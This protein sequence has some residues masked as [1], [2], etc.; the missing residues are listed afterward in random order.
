MKCFLRDVTRAS[1]A[2]G[3]LVATLV[4][5]GYATGREMS[6]YFG[7]AS[8]LTLLL[9]AVLIAAF[10]MAFLYVGA[11]GA[12]AEGRFTRCY[13]WVLS[14]LAVVSCGV[15]VAAGKA[16][17]AGEWTALLICLAGVFICLSDRVFHVANVVAVPILL[18]LVGIV[19][20]TA[21]DVAVG[22]AFMPLSA[23][24]YAGMNLLFEGELLRQEGKGMR[25]RA[26]WLAGGMIAV[27]MALLLGAM[28]RVVGASPSE[29]PFA[30]VADTMG[31]RSVAE[32]VI[33]ISVLSSIAGGMRVSLT[34]WQTKMPLSIA[35]LIALIV[36]LL[37]AVVPFADLV[38]YVYPVMGWIG[39]GVVAAYA[40]CA[41]VYY[42]QGRREHSNERFLRRKG[43][44]LH[45]LLKKGRI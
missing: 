30:M 14:V 24:N 42:V 8:W 26:I 38:R 35:A 3:V 19:A 15:M 28:H 33:L 40:V 39:V 4:G 5:A 2:T 1:R 32:G 17:L 7:D 31:R 41:V 27:C 34:V 6:Q 9:A 25:T 13:R 20:M 22:T 36:A 11:R 10:S 29:L 44:F 43:V 45:D 18:L 21:P 37:I 23:A 16:L 12:L